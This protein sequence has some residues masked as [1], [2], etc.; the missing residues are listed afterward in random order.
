MNWLAF[1]LVVAVTATRN[2]S[3]RIILPKISG[4]TDL[5]QG[6]LPYMVSIQYANP[7][8]NSSREHICGA[9]IV[10]ENWALTAAGCIIGPSF[11]DTHAIFSGSVDLQTGGRE[12]RLTQADVHENYSFFPQIQNDIAV[13]RVDPPFDFSL[14]TEES[15]VPLPPVGFDALEG[16]T[17]F[18]FGWGQPTPNLANMQLL[19]IAEITVIS[20]ETCSGVQNSPATE[21]CAGT[22]EGN[23]GTCYGDNGGPLVVDAVQAGIVSWSVACGTTQPSVFTQVSAYLDWISEH[24]AN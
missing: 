8:N 4:G 7:L 24:T 17:A 23:T 3:A 1:L 18:V 16:A 13:I 12:H 10:N 21:M 14:P 6:Q 5:P 19:Q 11:I 2:T 9:T 22:A 20:D 15:Q